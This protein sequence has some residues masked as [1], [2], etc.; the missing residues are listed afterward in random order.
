MKKI[1]FIL[2][3]VALFFISKNSISQSIANTLAQT[4]VNNT[5]GNFQKQTYTYDGN[6][7]LTMMLSQT[8]DAG[9]NNWRYGGSKIS[10]TNNTNGTVNSRLDTYWDINSSSWLN[11]LNIT[12][13]YNSGSSISELIENQHIIIYPNPIIDIIH[14][15]STFQTSDIKSIDILGI[16]GKLIKSMKL[17][18][19]PINVSYLPEGF[20]LIKFIL[21][22]EVYVSKFYKKQ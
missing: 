5:W 1:V 6:G 3:F 16:D 20:Y 22:E 9:T 13:T 8:W 2:A 10:Y 21:N 12:Y 14:F 7:Y 4:W 17:V 15:K 11:N 18:N 19:N